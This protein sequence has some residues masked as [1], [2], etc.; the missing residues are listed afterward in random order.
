MFFI[1]QQG[2]ANIFV[3]IFPHH[4]YVMEGAVSILQ[5][6]AVLKTF[7]LNG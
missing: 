4:F 7:C 6:P 2:S 1:K 3:Y 5:Q